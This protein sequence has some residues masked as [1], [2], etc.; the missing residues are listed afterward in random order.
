MGICATSAKK[1]DHT[2]NRIYPYQITNPTA[3]S[4]DSLIVHN[5]T[6][7]VKMKIILSVLD[8]S[9]ISSQD[10][11]R[12]K[13]ANQSYLAKED[14]DLS[15]ISNPPKQSDT[16]P[17]KHSG[18]DFT[19]A[20]FGQNE[21]VIANSSDEDLISL[22]ENDK[23]I[24]L[25]D[26]RNSGSNYQ[27]KNQKNHI[28]VDSLYK[29]VLKGTIPQLNES[30]INAAKN[31]L[32]KLN[33][34]KIEKG[35]SQFSG[36][37]TG[38]ELLSCS[39]YVEDI[40]KLKVKRKKDKNLDNQIINDSKNAVKNQVLNGNFI[41]E[42]FVESFKDIIEKNSQAITLNTEDSSK[43]AIDYSNGSIIKINGIK[44][45][46]KKSHFLSPERKKSDTVCFA[47][48]KNLLKLETF[49]GK[50]NSVTQIST[51][52]NDNC[53]SQEENVYGN[54]TKLYNF[55]IAQLENS[56]TSVSD[57]QNWDNLSRQKK[58][59]DKFQAAPTQSNLTK[60]ISFEK[61]NL[62]NIQTN[63]NAKKLHNSQ[64][65]NT[66][67][68]HQK[69][70]SKANLQLNKKIATSS[71]ISE[72]ANYNSSEKTNFSIRKLEFNNQK[73]KSIE[74]CKE[75]IFEG[76]SPILQANVTYESLVKNLNSE[77][78]RKI[79]SVSQDSKIERN[80]F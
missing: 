54:F 56:E 73:T 25:S 51:M 29:H 24:Q 18:L 46:I 21:S 34:V 38:M 69:E 23:N 7:S 14:R 30:E 58:N 70:A 72:N 15:K 44:S 42:N 26:D 77:M 16:N 79:G 57:D 35:Q 78:K 52:T 9:I 71:L 13:K 61:L 22:E 6:E 50:L 5:E 17:K 20:D 53:L 2:D 62:L 27:R 68:P 59:I 67:S 3:S 1:K 43:N 4:N 45:A 47:D 8:D 80:S 10:S 39:Q 19:F 49:G 64:Q 60:K 33:D 11:T 63:Q 36:K 41:E 40:I 65:I 12:I 28:K 55:R 75:I 48:Q 76:L 32:K 74:K 31:R 66:V 37:N